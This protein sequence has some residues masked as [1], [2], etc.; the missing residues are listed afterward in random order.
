MRVPLVSTAVLACALVLGCGDPPRSTAPTDSYEPSLGAQKF[1][2]VSNLA[3]GGDP[4][5]PLAMMVGYDA[6]T[7]PE[8]ACDD[9]GG[10]GLDLIGQ[11]I[12]LPTGGV[13]LRV[14]G[15]S[16]NLVVV[17]FGQ[18]PVTDVCQLVGAPIIATGTG[19]ATFEGLAPKPGAAFVAHVTV[20]G[21]V[22]LNAGGQARVLGTARV[23]VLPDGTLLFD[24]ERVTLTPI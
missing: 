7:T 14:S 23:T 6:G 8:Q 12:L 1:V 22:N 19:K 21:I 9:P 4:S 11:V 16:I 2:N 13:Q 15:K 24:E 5:N 3:I 10:H 20:Q 18:G 17:E